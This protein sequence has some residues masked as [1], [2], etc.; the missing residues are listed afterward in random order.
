[1]SKKENKKVKVAEATEVKEEVK[2]VEANEAIESELVESST[3]EEETSKE[4]TSD[5]VVKTERKFRPFHKIVENPKKTLVKTVELA[6]AFGLGCLTVA[7]MSKKQS[8]E[9]N[10][11]IDAEFTESD[12]NVDINEDQE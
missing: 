4:D 6:T 2:A 12:S 7:A 11:V 10:E 5:V 1:M 8:P 9:T 3:V